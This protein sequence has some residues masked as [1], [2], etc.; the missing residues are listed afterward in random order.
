MSENDIEDGVAATFQFLICW[1]GKTK[2]SRYFVKF[3][4]DQTSLTRQQNYVSPDDL[5]RAHAEFQRVGPYVQGF[6]S[7]LAGKAIRAEFIAGSTPTD[8]PAEVHP[9]GDIDDPKDRV[10]AFLFVL[11][12]S[13]L[14]EQY[15]VHF[16][17]KRKKRGESSSSASA[18]SS[19]DYRGGHAHQPA[20]GSPLRH[21]FE[22]GRRDRRASKPKTFQSW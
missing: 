22:V 4:F 17:M 19:K 12:P 20:Q 10:I 15:H 6:V 18:S 1:P 3:A 2:P 16:L 7:K 9:E 13:T 8:P 14:Y 5:A 21:V 11:G